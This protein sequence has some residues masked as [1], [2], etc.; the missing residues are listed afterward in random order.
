MPTRRQLHCPTSTLFRLCTTRSGS[1][2]PPRVGPAES[3]Q[4]FEDGAGM[5]VTE[6][7]SASALLFEGQ[8]LILHV[9]SWGK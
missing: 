4:Y 3:D 9:V 8:L 1:P 6:Q 5:S 7:I 2:R